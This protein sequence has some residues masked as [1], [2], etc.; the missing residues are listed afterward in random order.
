[1]T[2]LAYYAIIVIVKYLNIERKNK[3]EKPKYFIRKNA[4]TLDRKQGVE[5]KLYPD[6][7]RIGRKAVAVALVLTAAFGVS[8]GKSEGADSTGST[9]K[10]LTGYSTEEIVST[11][12]VKGEP[13]IDGWELHDGEAPDDAIRIDNLNNDESNY[14]PES[15]NFMENEVV[16][17]LENLVPE[18]WP[19]GSF[20]YDPSLSCYSQD[21]QDK[22]GIYG[23]PTAFVEFLRTRGGVDW[24]TASDGQKAG[25]FVET[26]RECLPLDPY[27]L[28][29]MLLAREYSTIG[30]ENITEQQ[31]QELGD[32]LNND[33]DSWREKTEELL[34]A[35]STS[36]LS[37]R[38][39]TAGE[40]GSVYQ[41]KDGMVEISE[42]SNVTTDTLLVVFSGEVQEDGTIKGAGAIELKECLQ[43][44]VPGDPGYLVPGLKRGEDI[45]ETTIFK[46]KVPQY[47][48][49]IDD[50][51]PPAIPYF[52]PTPMV[53]PVETLDGKPTP[54]APS[55]EDLGGKPAFS[56]NNPRFNR[57]DKTEKYAKSTGH[58]RIAGHHKQPTYLNNGAGKNINRYG[59]QGK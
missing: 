30:V 35:I 11:H 43:Y 51:Q 53:P 4:E 21:M 12:I 52:L 14:G 28:A 2:N 59:R 25:V 9:E 41:N 13:F 39:A 5:A 34:N 55:V 16:P 50:G 3:N 18:E 8:G 29:S 48:I 54:L 45:P 46:V 57:Y 49:K 7:A 33:P 38:T 10:V 36:R 37:I 27:V 44:V 17:G 1:M 56:A 40:H 26:M 23:M 20:N 42:V 32:I 31:I 58:A 24:S 19:E 15:L 6:R 22:V 47:K